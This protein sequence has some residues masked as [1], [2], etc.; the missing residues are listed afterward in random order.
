VSIVQGPS[1]CCP[2][3]NP[4]RPIRNHVTVR[5]EAYAAQGKRGQ[6]SGTLF[7]LSLSLS[8]SPA[9]RTWPA[10]GA[11]HD[12]RRCSTRGASLAWLP[13]SCHPHPLAAWVSACAEQAPSP[14]REKQRSRLAE[15][16]GQDSGP[17]FQQRRWSTVTPQVARGWARPPCRHSNHQSCSCLGSA[18]EVAAFQALKARASATRPLHERPQQRMRSWCTETRVSAI[19]RRCAGFESWARTPFDTGRR[20]SPPPPQWRSEPP[21][22][23]TP[24]A[25]TLHRP[26]PVPLAARSDGASR[27]STATRPRR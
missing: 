17:G 3:P 26:R 13:W 21:R 5:R 18:F 14:E 24:T 11:A 4:T 7:S 2:V 22:T 16:E 20:S 1:S 8:L 19:E 9:A 12:G 25:R 27:L 10:R 6:C 23:R 15:A